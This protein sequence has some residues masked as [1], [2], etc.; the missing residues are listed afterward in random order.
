MQAIQDTTEVRNIEFSAPD[1]Y[2]LENPNNNDFE[3]KIK[4]FGETE[5]THIQ[6]AR[7]V[8]H[9]RNYVL[10][11]QELSYVHAAYL[12]RYNLT[13]NPNRLALLPKTW[14]IYF[15]EV[16][17]LKLEDLEHIKNWENADKIFVIY[18]RCA[19]TITGKIAELNQSDKIR[20]EQAQIQ[21]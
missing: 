4:S 7:F 14:K 9:S 15:I 6:K 12:H 11:A 17:V 18:T 16:R 8:D 19:H 13:A 5:L 2:G 21:K 20:I 3:A 1:F 10:F